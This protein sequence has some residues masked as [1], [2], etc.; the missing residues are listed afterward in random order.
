MRRATTERAMATLS[1]VTALGILAFWATF[2]T[3]G[4]APERAPECYFAYEHSF[5]LPDAALAGTLLSAAH[6]VL[7]GRPLGRAL[8]LV[9]SGGL[10]F[11]GLVDVAFNLQQGIYAASS[12]DLLA[13]AAI[14]AWCLLLGS[15]LAVCFAR[16]TP[17]PASGP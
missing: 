15:L 6:L 13:N 3:V 12:A 5:P 7:R 9:A 4:L 10:L 17:R 1:A 8:A 2:F 14:N 11:L 16:P